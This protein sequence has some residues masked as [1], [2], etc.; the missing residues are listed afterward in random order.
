[1]VNSYWMNT[2]LHYCEETIPLQMEHFKTS[3]IRV[4]TGRVRRKDSIEPLE[5]KMF[6]NIKSDPTASADEE[7]LEIFRAESKAGEF[8]RKPYLTQPGME[9]ARSWRNITENCK[10]TIQVSKN[11]R[12]ILWQGW[13]HWTIQH[14][15]LSNEK[16]NREETSEGTHRFGND[17]YNFDER[18]R[19][20]AIHSSNAIK[21]LIE[22][23]FWCCRARCGISTDNEQ[24][25]K[26]VLP[27]SKVWRF[28]HWRLVW[29]QIYRPVLR[30]LLS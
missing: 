18:K 16:E 9:F 26:I 4:L 8:R 5:E 10:V 28:I 13:K 23:R 27:Q 24:G 3:S 30:D 2:W 11:R 6:P 12:K 1:M 21:V 14:K 17:M 20:P 29:A 15:S 19:Y 22:W 25:E 7:K